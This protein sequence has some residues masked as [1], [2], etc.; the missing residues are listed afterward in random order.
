MSLH[1]ALCALLITAWIPAGA[2]ARD[3]TPNIE[4]HT[5]DNGMRVYLLEDHSA[6]IFTFQLWAEV[7][8]ADEWQSKQAGKT[9]ITGLSHFFEHMMFR[10]TKR[11]PKY[12]GELR[13][14]GGKLNAFTWLDVTVYW[15]KMAREYL[16]FILD[17]ESDR[18]ANMKVDFLNLE[19][20]REVVKSE[21]LLRTENS[22][23][24]S[25]YEA[26]SAALFAKHSYHWPTVGWMDDLNG[27]T[28]KQAQDYH[29]QFYG[30]NNCFIVLVGDF[31]SAEA[32][33]LVKKYF[34]P[35]KARPFTRQKRHIEP[36][37]S[38]EERVYVEK[39][40]GTGLLQLVYPAPA[41]AASDFVAMEVVEQL[42]TGG[43]TSRLD[44]VL[45]RGNNPV[46]KSVSSF[47]FP[48]VDASGIFIDVALLP[49]KSNRVAEER[50]TA[51]IERISNE[52]VNADELSRAVAQL[53]AGIV[54]SLATTQNRAQMMGFAIRASGDPQTPWTRL[55]AYGEVTPTQIQAAARKWLAPKRRVI[56]HAVH[57]DTLVKLTHRVVK[58]NPS[59]KELDELLTQ[60]MKYASSIRA[61]RE[62]ERSM[63]QEGTAIKLLRERGATEQRRIEQSNNKNKEEALKAL[64]K[65][66]EGAQK[67]AGKR[68][69]LL[70]ERTKK[71]TTGK[72]ALEKNK[73]E[74]IAKLESKT[75]HS[76]RL[77][78]R[79]LL[80][81]ETAENDDAPSEN[82][83]QL[84]EWA[85]EKLSLRAFTKQRTSSPLA[86]LV[87]AA[88]KEGLLLKI[89]DFAHQSQGRS[90]QEISR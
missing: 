45:V 82:S 60:S 43:K 47:M 85:L 90:L 44:Q 37:H 35:L 63:Q 86:A 54:R 27:I 58:E 61:L 20:E 65:Y 31:K 49:E 74:L 72:E 46:A 23:S 78:A 28:L 30:P 29:R 22:A 67:G 2:A 4:T 26:T 53:R 62:E 64:K 8:S 24:G 83:A 73:T 36:I 13:K 5:L 76:R 55:K 14:R 87:K 7:G 33:A 11:Y 52:S 77:W 34:G 57:P 68:Q 50:V 71:L 88:P 38:Q 59:E 3:L 10:G 19:P 56:G 16:E 79:R 69:K 89:W 84:S 6:P 51:A 21:R 12:F 41:G 42:L 17:L 66:M 9:G 70:D 48:F 25:L 75:S 32:L 80:G 81:L 15:E 39:P 1:R 40:T 18:F